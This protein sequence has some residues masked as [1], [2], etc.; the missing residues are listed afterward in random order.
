MTYRVAGV[1]G[2]VSDP[3]DMAFLGLNYGGGYGH[4]WVGDGSGIWRLSW[5]EHWPA[6]LLVRVWREGSEWREWRV[7]VDVARARASSS[8][9]SLSSSSSSPHSDEASSEEDGGHRVVPPP[10]PPPLL[11]LDEA[12]AG[13]NMGLGWPAQHLVG[14][15]TVSGSPWHGEY[16]R[17][18][19]RRQEW[20]AEVR[21]L[22]RPEFRVEN[23]FGVGS[24][25]VLV[26]WREDWGEEGGN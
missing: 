3:A 19:Q 7:A 24:D 2:Y 12:G 11:P 10:P 22:V 8:V 20:L 13:G 9:V 4:S 17:Q 16:Q 14:P 6:D 21:A 26:P 1:T 18:V 23:G 15:E 5:T 25:G